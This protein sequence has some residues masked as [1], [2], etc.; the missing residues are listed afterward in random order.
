MPILKFR[1]FGDKVVL[2]KLRMQDITKD[3]RTALLNRAQFLCDR[4]RIDE[5]VYM[6]KN[7]TFFKLAKALDTSR[8]PIDAMIV[9]ENG[10]SIVFMPCKSYVFWN[11][12]SVEP[13]KY[14]ILETPENMQLQTQIMNGNTPTRK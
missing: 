2:D 1:R 7:D 3:K 9:R 13:E 8:K 6:A 10:Y 4:Y 12:R 11:G 5:N 14:Q